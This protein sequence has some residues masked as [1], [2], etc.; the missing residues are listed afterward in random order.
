[1]NHMHA[2]YHRRIGHRMTPTQAIER[3]LGHREC[4]ICGHCGPDVVVTHRY[5]GGR[6][7]VD[8]VHCQ[9]EVACSRRW[10]LANGFT[11]AH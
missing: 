6:G 8:Q 3:I 2:G 10:N 7:Y 9:D 4:P 1:M 5:V 11:P